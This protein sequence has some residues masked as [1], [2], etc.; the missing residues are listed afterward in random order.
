MAAILVEAVTQSPLSRLA[1]LGFHGGPRRSPRYDRSVPRPPLVLVTGFGP[2]EN[3]RFNPSRVI[4]ATLEREPPPGARVRS[5]ELPVSFHGA[6]RDVARFVSRHARSHPV[7]LLGLG[8]QRAGS[9]RF[10]S[11]ARGRYT[12]AR[13]DNDGTAGATLGV[14]AGKTLRTSLDVRAL[15][16]VMRQ[17]GAE[18]VRVSSD[19]GGYVCERTY[20]ALLSAGEAH[21]V[22]AVFLHVPPAS[23]V[24]SATQARLVRAWLARWLAGRAS[25]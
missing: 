19:A 20:H 21:G 4:A 16:R 9:F 14:S 23:V 22:D 2:F 11:R 7:L 5:R 13:T 18:S 25:A 1:R 17:V 10:E 6:P 8:V 12:T 15:A 24:R 3:R